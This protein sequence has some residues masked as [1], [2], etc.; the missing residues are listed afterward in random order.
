MT[1]YTNLPGFDYDH[2]RMCGVA[3]SPAMADLARRNVEDA[4]C[5]VPAC[6]RTELITRFGCCAKAEILGCVCHYAFRCPVHG[7]KHIG[8]HD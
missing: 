8:T 7:D 1:D 3:V 5:G 6:Y 4:H 2:C